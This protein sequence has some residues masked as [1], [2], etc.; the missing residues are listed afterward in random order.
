MDT[1]V[2]VDA[3]L[4]M[5]RTR[6]RK[7]HVAAHMAAVR[8]VGHGGLLVCLV[9]VVYVY[10]MWD[11]GLSPELDCGTY[12]CIVGLEV[13]YRSTDSLMAE[14]DNSPQQH[15]ASQ[16]NTDGTN[17]S[18]R[19]AQCGSKYTRHVPKSI[20]FMVFFHACTS[21]HRPCEIHCSMPTHG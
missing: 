11:L 6:S 14:Q 15:I 16:H 7:Q 17:P 3:R 20:E 10:N 12:V 9:G 21:M 5:R 13:L 18:W 4:K 1:V 2:H 8:N 19:F